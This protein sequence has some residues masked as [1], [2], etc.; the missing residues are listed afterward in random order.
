MM[1]MS[2]RKYNNMT[3]RREYYGYAKP[4][5]A[6]VCNLLLVYAAFMLCRL[7]FLVE[8]WKY[9][10]DDMTTDLFFSIVKGGLLFDTSAILY[11]NILYVLLVLFPIH[12]KDST[13][14][15]AVVKWLFVITNSLAVCANLADSVY[16]QYTNRRTTS[17]VFREFSNEGNLAS[18]F[19]DEMLSHWYLVLLAAFIIFA[20]WKLYSG[21]RTR[22][23]YRII[24]YYL[25]QLLS[26]AIAVPLVIAGMRGGFTTAVRPVTV[27]NA[28]QYVNKPIETALVLNTP[29]SLYRT[30]GKDVFEVPDYFVDREEM[31]RLF[32]PVHFPSDSAVFNP[33]N[34][35]VL[36]MESFGREYSGLY[37]RDLKGE[38]YGYMPFLDSLSTQ[39]LVFR[40]SFANGRKSIDGMPSVL[41]G[42]PMFIEPFFLTPSSLNRVSGIARELLGKGYHTAFFHGADNGSMGFQAFARAT[43]YNSYYGRQEYGND[44]DF[45]GTWAVWDKP[46]FSYFASVLD[47]LQQPFV[48]GLFSASSHHPFRIPEEDEGRFKEGTLP[49]HKC[50]MYSDDALRQFFNKASGMD[51]YDNT[52]F[53]VTADHTSQ[54]DTPQYL[55]DAGVFSVPILFYC[56]SDSTLRGHREGIAQQIDIM[57]TV[58]GYLGYDRPY[59]AFGCNLLETP[60]DETF[61]VNYINGIYQYYK[62]DYLLQFD[63]I[64]SVAL[65]DYVNDSLLKTNIMGQHPETVK[66]M[67]NTL[68][69]VI[70]QYMERMTND[71]LV[72][73]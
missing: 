65:Y 12:L 25:S 9:F 51:W 72:Y 33:K 46:F 1:R 34:V 64:K 47:T 39:G 8:N 38:D 29:F 17:S 15:A 30:I 56:P 4:M 70:Q 42:I 60:D 22:A 50:I 13:P 63:G 62:G 14:Y 21:Y 31:Q 73:E 45:D 69:S 68:K 36:I 7:E 10:A 61:A 6:V 67:E 48:A 71:A 55:T 20:F 66:Q 32:N 3:D 35:V 11:T 18:I 52:L 54:S 59:V 24:P 28:N 26:L 27:S 49:I 43:G 58:L 5:I 23:H 53:V 16:F 19:V 40:H 44:A 37:N 57:P 41:S 2:Y